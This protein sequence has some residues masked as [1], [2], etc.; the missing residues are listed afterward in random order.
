MIKP[1]KMNKIFQKINTM[2][3]EQKQKE[4][5]RKDSFRINTNLSS[6]PVE[7][8]RKSI[9]NLEKK[10]KDKEEEIKEEIKKNKFVDKSKVND[11]IDNMLK[12]KKQKEEVRRAS[13]RLNTQSSSTNVEDRFERIN[14][15]ENEK[16]DKEEENKEEIKKNKFVDK[17]KMSDRID[18]ML[19]EKKQKESEKV[20]NV[21]QNYEIPE[22]I[23]QKSEF[24]GGAVEN[25]EFSETTNSENIIQNYN[26]NIK[27]LQLNEENINKIFGE[28]SKELSNEQKIHL[29]DRKINNCQINEKIKLNITMINPNKEYQYESEIYDDQDKLI[30]KTKQQGDKNE[31]ILSDNSEINYIFTKTK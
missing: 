6:T 31:I 3:Q 20:N 15:I 18:N 26:K 17:R 29:L 13:F 2:L 14:N 5:V 21:K 9:N 30:S 27:L 23:I 25:S 7:D 22:I 8:M 24:L 11:R 16:K 10:K 12:E 1:S 4:K 19:K 28:K